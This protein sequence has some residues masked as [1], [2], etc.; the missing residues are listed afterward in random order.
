MTREYVVSVARQSAVLFLTTFCSL[1]TVEQEVTLLG[2][3]A[4]AVAALLTVARGLATRVTGDPN[5]NQFK[6]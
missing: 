6:K 2:L 4:A 3:K 1:I 5:S